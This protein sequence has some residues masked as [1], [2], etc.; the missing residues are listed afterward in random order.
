MI[1]L[2]LALIGS[3][4]IS[5]GG[6]T[7][8]LVTELVS[9]IGTVA[10]DEQALVAFAG[11]WVTWVNGIIDAGRDPTAEEEAAARALAD[12]VHANNQSLAQGGSPV[13]LPSPPH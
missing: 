2:L 11:P 8:A 10:L 7:G 1:Q 12:A 9:T 5:L 4:G 13:T 3:L 6:K